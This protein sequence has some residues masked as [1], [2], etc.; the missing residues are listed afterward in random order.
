MIPDR[1]EAGERVLW[2]DE[3]SGRVRA[4]SEVLSPQ[5]APGNIVTP[6]FGGRFYYLSGEGALWELRAARALDR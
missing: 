1:G 4:R 2:L 6:G 3:R 5:A